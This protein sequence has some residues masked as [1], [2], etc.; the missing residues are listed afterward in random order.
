MPR[1][2]IVANNSGRGCERCG[3]V[4]NATINDFSGSYCNGCFEHLK[5]NF[6]E[7]RQRMLIK[8][9]ALARSLLRNNIYVKWGGVGL[10]EWS[11][12]VIIPRRSTRPKRVPMK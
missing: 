6:A 5:Q 7:W 11:Y 1:F 2:A 9:A 12:T 8:K 3:V 10:P 4:Q